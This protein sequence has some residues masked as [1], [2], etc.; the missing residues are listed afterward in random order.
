VEE[1]V[2]VNSQKNIFDNLKKLMARVNVKCMQCSNIYKADKD[3]VEKF[4]EVQKNKG[5]EDALKLEQT[6]ICPKCKANRWSLVPKKKFQFKIGFNF[7][8]IRIAISNFFS[9]IIDLG[10]WFL[11]WLEYR[12]QV[13]LR[14]WWFDWKNVVCR[15]GALIALIGTIYV[16]KDLFKAEFYQVGLCV[17]G[18]YAIMKFS[19]N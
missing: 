15:G 7:K 3:E 10:L 4:Q 13:L 18:L 11:A 14:N 1:E 9:K 16:A 19:K 2:K 12:R 6:I 8:G 17:A 5:I